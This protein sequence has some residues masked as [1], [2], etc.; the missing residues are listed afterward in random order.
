MPSGSDRATG[1]ADDS[2]AE[3]GLHHRRVAP[4]PAG[5]AIRFHDE[6]VVETTVETTGVAAANQ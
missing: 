4:E 2:R 5:R 3:E 1:S 6:V